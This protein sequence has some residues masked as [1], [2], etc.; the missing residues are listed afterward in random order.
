MQG[1]TK[2]AKKGSQSSGSPKARPPLIEPINFADT[3]DAIQISW[4]H[5]WAQM[6]D[7]IEMTTKTITL[8]PQAVRDSDGSDLDEEVYNDELLRLQRSELH[9]IAAR[10]V[11]FQTINM[12]QWIANHVDFK[13]M[14]IISDE[15]K[16]LGLLTPS[17]LHSLYHLKPMEAKC[18][19]EYLDNFHLKHPKSC[20]VM[21][22]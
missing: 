18:N 11:I 13:R 7:F 9:L 3:S 17:N 19:K 10:P 1:P 21:K 4:P 20:E 5:M 16:S 12:L 14:A 6:Y 22:D 2:K 8:P 15:G